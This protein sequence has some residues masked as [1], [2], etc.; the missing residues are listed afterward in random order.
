MT[1]CQLERHPFPLTCH[2]LITLNH[3]HFFQMSINVPV[4]L[5]VSAISFDVGPA[6]ATA[7]PPL[8]VGPMPAP[9]LEGC[10]S[11]FAKPTY[12]HTHVVLH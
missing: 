9:F 4:L 8:V 10:I 5:H 3:V 2:Q 7:A 6:A 11:S 1:E 12:P